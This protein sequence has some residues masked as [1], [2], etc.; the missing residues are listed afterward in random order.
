CGP[1]MFN[2]AAIMETF[3]DQNA[4]LQV[5]DSGTLSAMLQGLLAVPDEITALGARAEA[6]CQTQHETLP[7]L[8]AA[9][10]GWRQAVDPAALRGAA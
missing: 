10:A 4:I 9:L 8:W 7:R 5:P 3:K 1:H 2:F 6:V